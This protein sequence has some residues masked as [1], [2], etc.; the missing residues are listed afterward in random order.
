MCDPIVRGAVVALCAALC[1]PACKHAESSATA[2]VE[3]AHGTGQEVPPPTEPSRAAPVAAPP[4]AEF[5]KSVDPKDLDAAERKVLAEIL[6]EQFDPCGKPR[7][8]QAALETA[9]CPLAIKLGATVVK[10]LQAGHGKKPAVAMLL[11]EIERLN[12]VVQVDVAGAPSLGPA[13]AKVTVVEY[14]DFECPYCRHS[15]E[16]LERLQKHYNFLLY[17]RFF[18]LKLAHPNA[19]GTAKAAW[20]AH[21]QG[22]FWPLHDAMFAHQEALDWPSVQKLATG[23]G[24]DMKRFVADFGSPAAQAAVDAS[25]KSGEA[26]G[27]DGTPTFFVNGRRAETLMQVQELVRDVQTQAGGTLPAALTPDDLGESAPAAAPAQRA[28]GTGEDKAPETAPAPD[29]AAPA[30]TQA[31]PTPS[32]TK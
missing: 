2:S 7:S 21:Q 19:E 12:T 9:D 18:P 32:V 15:V 23:L 24:I 30:A 5:P 20:A 3:I 16:P 29:Q 11:R 25:T 1:L 4:T 22:K 6:A 26:A 8:F 13:D 17:Y 14:S 28:A 27:V 31:T 10:L